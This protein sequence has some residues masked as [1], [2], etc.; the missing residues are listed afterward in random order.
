MAEKRLTE[1]ASTDVDL[2][3]R[4]PK[5]PTQEPRRRSRPAFRWAASRVGDRSRMTD[6]KG[7]RSSRGTVSNDPAASDDRRS[8]S[9][10]GDP[11]RA[12]HGWEEAQAR[13]FHL[14]RRRRNSTQPAPPRPLRRIP[15]THLVGLDLTTRA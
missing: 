4:G 2:L 5:C 15:A 3:Q 6:E 14:W 1:T 12:P 13:R 8:W 9:A 7:C 11:A 10:V